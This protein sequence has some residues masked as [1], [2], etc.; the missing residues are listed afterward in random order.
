[1]K[2]LAFNKMP[3][4]AFKMTL[5][6]PEQQRSRKPTCSACKNART[7]MVGKAWQLLCSFGIACHDDAKRCESFKDARYASAENL[8]GMA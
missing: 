7:E 8:P 3:K 6:L 1:M 2:A 5:V 4:P